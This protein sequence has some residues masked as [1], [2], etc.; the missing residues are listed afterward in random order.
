MQCQL[1]LCAEGNALAQNLRREVIT[2]LVTDQRPLSCMV[3]CSESS[4]FFS[5]SPDGPTTPKYAG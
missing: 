1:G 5:G 3:D 4:A 2:V